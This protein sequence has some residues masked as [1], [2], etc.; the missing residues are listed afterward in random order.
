MSGSASSTG[1]IRIF[2][3]LPHEVTKTRGAMFEAMK[4]VVDMPVTV[5]CRLGVENQASKSL[6]AL[7]DGCLDQGVVAISWVHAHASLAST[8]V[9]ETK[10]RHHAF[11]LMNRVYD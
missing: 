5:K 7:A 10:N 3:S 9:S 2:G 6:D 1:A 4:Q 8:V 11:G